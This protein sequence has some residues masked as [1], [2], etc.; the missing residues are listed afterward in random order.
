MIKTNIHLGDVKKWSDLGSEFKTLVTIM[1]LLYSVIEVRGFD[2]V[3]LFGSQ[4]LY[5]INPI[6]NQI[7]RKIFE[8]L[9]LLRKER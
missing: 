7:S 3:N 1:N 2:L 5:N 9:L 8:H 6:V 4:I